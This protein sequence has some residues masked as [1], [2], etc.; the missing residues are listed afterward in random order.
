[1]NTTAQRCDSVIEK[2]NL[3][4]HPFYQ[5]WSNGTLP[6][7]ALRD[8]AREYGAFIAGIGPGWERAG[9][10][11]IAAIEEGHARV[12][13]RTF[14]AGLDT[15][16]GEPQISEVRSLVEA[17][18]E[19]FADRATALG[20]LYAFEAQQPHTAASKL[21]G[22]EEHYGE[23]AASCK[24]YFVLH[25][26]DFEEPA[27]LAESMESL[28]AA[29]REQ[30]VAACEKMSCALWDA[31]SGIHAPYAAQSSCAM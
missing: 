16:V 11:R 22:I 14:A 25:V 5:A 24:Q 13:E 28:S 4:Q 29:E 1:M 7:E 18:R 21:K 3:L 6:V 8:Y 23:L 19:L 26:D 2:K 30:A 20:A 31:L 27:M 10:S 15:H 12:W 17:E 9:Y